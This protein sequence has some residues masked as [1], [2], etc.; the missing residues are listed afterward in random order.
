MV[1]PNGTLN[2]AKA[3][4]SLVEPSKQGRKFFRLAR[5]QSGDTAPVPGHF[6][7]ARLFRPP[8]CDP[9]RLPASVG[10]EGFRLEVNSDSQSPEMLPI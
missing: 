1:E 7:T 3:A 6:I 9:I 10:N 5:D 2:G 4:L 8:E